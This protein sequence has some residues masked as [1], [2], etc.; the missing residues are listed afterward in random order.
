MHD[1]S[2]LVEQRIRRELND[3]LMPLMYRAKSPL[4]VEAWDTPGEPVPYADAMA[5]LAS[6]EARPFIIGRRWSRPWG[7]TW[8]RFTGEVPAEWAGGTVEAVIDLGFHPD[9]A[10]FQAEGLVWAPGADGRAY[11]CRACTRAAPR[12][13]WPPPPAPSVSSSRPPPTRP[14]R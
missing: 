14:S 10:G 6:D 12:C 9:S 11:P 3:R 13:P 8:F 7:T 2:T 4:T 5:A 1:D